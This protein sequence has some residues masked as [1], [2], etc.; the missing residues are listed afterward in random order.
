MRTRR[1]RPPSSIAHAGEAVLEG[2]AHVIGIAERERAAHAVGGGV[3]VVRIVEIEQVE[4]MALADAQDL[5][6]PVD[7]CDRASTR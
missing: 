3:G 6:A 2:Q 1:A 5:G 4:Q 7:A